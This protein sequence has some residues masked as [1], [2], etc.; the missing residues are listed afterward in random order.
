MGVDADTDFGNRKRGGVGQGARG[1]CVLFAS[2]LPAHL[3]LLFFSLGNS[4]F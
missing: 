2:C 4:T 3:R 1:K